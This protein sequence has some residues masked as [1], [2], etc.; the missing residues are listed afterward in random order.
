[1]DQEQ[2]EIDQIYNNAVH[3]LRVMVEDGK[4]LDDALTYATTQ[5]GLGLAQIAQIH[6]EA[7]THY[8]K[9]LA[10][11]IQEALGGIV[12][13]PLRERIANLRKGTAT[14]CFIRYDEFDDGI[15]P[16][17]EAAGVVVQ[18]ASEGAELQ[19]EV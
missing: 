5:C 14:T 16:K 17:V 11:K 3:K 12:P 6:E 1:M 18:D 9:I 15:W 19:G 8:T 10:D 7:K 2:Q 4:T 13:L